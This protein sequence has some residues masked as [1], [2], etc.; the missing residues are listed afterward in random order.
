LPEYDI[1]SWV[2]REKNPLRRQLREAVHTV[3]V[4]IASSSFLNV[5]M[6]MRGGILLAI[7]YDC[8]RYTTD[9]DFSTN[10]KSSN[11]DKNKLISELKNKLIIATEKL[12]YGLGCQVQAVK[13]NPPRPDANFPTL[14]IKIGYAYKEDK[15]NYKRLIDGRSVNVVK[16]DY[17][18][19][20][21]TKEIELIELKDGGSISV[22]SLIELVAEKYRAILQQVVRNRFRR[23]DVYDIFYLLEKY[24][25]PNESEKR[26]ILETLIIKSDSR[27]LDISK[28]SMANIEVIERS[29]KHYHHLSSEIEGD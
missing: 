18:F 10:I 15:K 1:A 22:Y 29:K 12:D 27:G 16:I 24:T 2:E 4:A 21:I 17:S 20:E 14:Q 19:N 8:S 7:K 11:F 13:L 9:I 28:E 25:E 23:Q 6:I 5:K 3:L 26:N